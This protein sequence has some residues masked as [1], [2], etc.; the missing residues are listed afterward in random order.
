[1]GTRLLANEDAE[2]F[3]TMRPAVIMKLFGWFW[4][5]YA[6]AAIVTFASAADWRVPGITLPQWCLFLLLV[7]L[8][9]SGF[10]SLRECIWARR[11]QAAL[12]LLMLAPM[13]ILAVFKVWRGAYDA[14]F[15]V[16]AASTV[17]AIATLAA[18]LSNRSVAKPGQ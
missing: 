18:H 11:I 6:L 4:M 15:W 1:M 16:S 2:P 5:M 8:F 12:M 13:S 10:Y 3:E 17:F 14:L 7:L 9:V